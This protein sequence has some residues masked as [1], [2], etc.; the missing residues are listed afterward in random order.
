[1][2]I[3]YN[4]YDSME[5]LCQAHN[6]QVNQIVC[7]FSDGQIRKRV[8]NGAGCGLVVN[9]EYSI[10]R[11]QAL[12]GEAPHARFRFIIYSQHGSKLGWLAH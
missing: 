6:Q 11:K 9:H 2:R 7:L 4:W 5:Q 3:L 10:E 1:M 8:V 12:Y